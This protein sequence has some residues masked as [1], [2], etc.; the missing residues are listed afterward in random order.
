MYRSSE[1][2]IWLSN[3]TLQWYN[4]IESGDTLYIFKVLPLFLDVNICLPLWY[5]VK[6]F[7]V[8][9]DSIRHCKVTSECS[10]TLFVGDINSFG[11]SMSK[12]KK[13]KIIFIL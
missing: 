4:P 7:T 13:Q 3:I 10:G 8:G 9:L 5:Q 6:W 2:C 1:T 12:D 11:L